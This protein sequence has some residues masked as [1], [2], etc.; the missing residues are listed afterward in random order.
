M[1][2][3]FGGK[4]SPDEHRDDDE[5]NAAPR[6]SSASFR[7][8][9]VDPVGIGANL[10]M[11]PPGLMVLMAVIS[12]AAGLG[13]AISHHYGI[14]PT[15]RS[16]LLHT[17]S[18]NDAVR[19]AARTGLLGAEHR[20]VVL[21]VNGSSALMSYMQRTNTGNSNDLWTEL[22][23]QYEA[24]LIQGGTS[25]RSGA[26]DTY[27]ASH[28]F[29]RLGPTIHGI[30]SAAGSNP[31]TVTGSS[32]FTNNRTHRAIQTAKHLLSNSDV[33][34]VGVL[35]Q[36]T[37]SGWD[38]HLDDS[39]PNMGNHMARVTTNFYNILHALFS[40]S[41]PGS[42][43]PA[44][45]LVVIRTEFGRYKNV[46]DQMGTNHSPWG[47]GTLLIGGP[48]TGGPSVTGSL[49]QRSP[50]DPT[51]KGQDA[52]DAYVGS[53]G[54]STS[55][56]YGGADIQAAVLE[57]AGLNPFTSLFST[58]DLATSFASVSA[59]RSALNTHLL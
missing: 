49:V 53:G 29:M 8:A 13:A 7:N 14:A 10:M 4:Y 18:F 41:G 1:A 33:K 30:L 54:T 26:L 52:Q 20:P 16:Y 56:R 47:F 25:A 42:F 57:A 55:D 11:V 3:R 27:L 40:V 48:I 32:T 59:A 22:V 19:Y 36:G 37:T 35:D 5:Q 2:K 50:T 21:P 43:S 24:R 9:R 23:E 34:Y 45:V 28:D 31:L 12:D 39:Y 17:G 46:A 6:S 51:D 44:N 38:T 15:P 58:S